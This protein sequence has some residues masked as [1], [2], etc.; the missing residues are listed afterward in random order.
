VEER[1][2]DPSDA[3][4]A[5]LADAIRGSAVAE[6][7]WGD[8]THARARLHVYLAA[9]RTWYDRDVAFEAGDALDERERAI[10]FL[11]GVMIRETEGMVLSLP[12]R[13]PP[14]TSQTAP[15][16]PT[17]AAEVPAPP[18]ARK[19][20]RRFAVDVRG[21]MTT[22]IEGDAASL[23]PSVHAGVVVAESLALDA[24]GSLGF[25]S[26][27]GADA[28]MTTTRL[29]AGARW[30][31]LTIGRDLS[32][33]VGL[34]ALAV[35]HAV[36]R[37]DPAADRSRWLAGGHAD[38]GLGWQASELVEPFVI[39]GVDA[40][41]GNTPINVGGARLGHIPPFRAVL[42]LGLKVHF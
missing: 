30:R 10:G 13:P 24:G 28:R 18:I 1:A 4:A 21:V 22:G 11:V 42:E 20:P 33:D 37:A 31:W 9:D 34:A 3:E 29:V 14:V 23:G 26:I 40:V 6:I 25:G 15:P 12:A 39:G 17:S 36:R 27:E 41:S 19:E 32:F 8:E 5:A 35:H 16:V 2:D 38:V 7:A